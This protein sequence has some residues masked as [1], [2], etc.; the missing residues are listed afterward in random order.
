LIKEYDCI[1]N[2]KH[3]DIYYVI[4]SFPLTIRK[5][6]NFSADFDAD[7]ISN[8]TS[9]TPAASDPS[10]EMNAPSTE[11]IKQFDFTKKIQ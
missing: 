7:A 9:T 2:L 10:A 4:D 3:G 11:K 8:E 5:C 6:P 1:P